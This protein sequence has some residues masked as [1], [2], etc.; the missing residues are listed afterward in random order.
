[1]L[2]NRAVHEYVARHN[3][4]KLSYQLSV[5]SDFIHP[6][7][8]RL[9]SGR[10]EVVKPMLYTYDKVAKGGVLAYRAKDVDAALLLIWQ[11]DGRRRVSGVYVSKRISADAY[12]AVVKLAEL[13][14]VGY[15]K[16]C[17]GVE[18][19]VAGKSIEEIRKMLRTYVSPVGRQ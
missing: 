18:E 6:L 11:T 13:L 4:L 8:L 19:A 14:W 7:V 5:A 15:G 10:I 1:M 12:A 2:K 3:L 17:G 16:S 9:R